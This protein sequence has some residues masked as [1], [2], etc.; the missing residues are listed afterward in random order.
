MG[1]L[2]VLGQVQSYNS[3]TNQLIFKLDFVD[4]NT[5]EQ[6]EELVQWSKP[7]KFSFKMMKS[8]KSRTYQQ[9]KKFWVD[10][11]KIMKALKIENTKENGS[12]LYWFIRC[13]IFPVKE[14][15]VGYDEHDNPVHKP[16]P[17]EMKELTLEEMAGVIGN[18][19]EHYSYLDI[20]WSVRE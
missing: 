1:K 10:V 2:E 9:Q 17:P 15:M 8:F 12:Q 7:V 18:L 20:D 4:L 13:N 19:H 6:I 11:S 14:A 3:D 16:Y 5:I